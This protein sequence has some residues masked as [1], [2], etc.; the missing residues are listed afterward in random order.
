MARE[1]TVNIPDDLWVD[2]WDEQLT[3]TYTYPG[4][5][6]LWLEI[7]HEK[8]HLYNVWVEKPDADY[9]TSVQ[10]LNSGAIIEEFTVNSDDT[11]LMAYLLLS[12]AVDYT[13]SVDSEWEYIYEDE[14]QYDGSVYK[15]IT[16]PKVNDVYYIR[17]N[18]H[19]PG[20]GTI[21]V[22]PILKDSQNR[23]EILA[24][25][26]LEYLKSFTKSFDF[27]DTPEMQTTI[28]SLE[29]FISLH[30]NVYPWK[31]ITLDETTIPKIP[32]A[33]AKVLSELPES[34]GD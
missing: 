6:S 21:S 29:S 31:F 5:D 4:P 15:K 25:R 13:E 10:A 19:K 16:N 22:Q 2:S 34:M 30:S 3:A 20:F 11:A 26:R 23:L 9:I 12:H 27:S 28:D 32:V 24:H 17:C 1:F 8:K 14:I 33:L 7:N 18:P